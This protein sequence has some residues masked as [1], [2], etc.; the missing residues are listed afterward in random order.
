MDFDNH[1]NPLEVTTP[2]DDAPATVTQEE[3]Q[4]EVSG[5]VTTPTRPKRTPRIPVKVEDIINTAKRV[6]PHFQNSG[7]S[8]AWM[9]YTQFETL[10]LALDTT[11]GDKKNSLAVRKAMTHR[12][13]ELDAEIN[14][15][16]SH[17]KAYVREKFG[18]LNGPPNYAI[19][20]IERLKK[21]TYRFPVD[22]D[23][24]LRALKQMVLGIT[25]HDLQ[26]R[27]YGLSYWEDT[28]TEYE[29]LMLETGEHD[30]NNA[31]RTR[32]KKHYIY[33]IKRA[34]RSIYK[35]LEA[36]YP[37]TFRSVARHWGFHKEKH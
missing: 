9:T 18:R 37:D 30:G 27:T 12:L 19:F 14:R 11:E 25:A 10:V 4:N 17:V 7:F 15:N 29:N 35:L 6:L 33:Q 13:R 22:R 16:V 8:L 31:D 5:T 3:T 28:L 34:L 2:A 24:R 23:N 1:N 21:S 20:G 36:N 26:N 32:T